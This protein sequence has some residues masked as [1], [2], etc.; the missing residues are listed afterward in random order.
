MQRR[1][2]TDT[3]FHGEFEESDAGDHGTASAEALWDEEE[4]IS[5]RHAARPGYVDIDP[6]VMTNPVFA[7][8]DNDGVDELIVAA[9]YFFDRD[10]YDAPVW[11]S[12]FGWVCFGVLQAVGKRCVTTNF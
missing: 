11:E 2:R 10:Y 1:G 3:L 9:S 4:F 5:T 12:G 7:D 8:I 6:H